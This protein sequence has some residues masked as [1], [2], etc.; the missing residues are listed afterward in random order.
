MIFVVDP[1]I[2][3]FVV[4]GGLFGLGALWGA[5]GRVRATQVLIHQAV[6]HTIQSLIADGFLAVDHDSAGDMVIL[7]LS[8]LVQRH[9]DSDAKV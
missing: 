1:H 4:A 7:P 9:V 8:Q 3:T 6:D 2:A 5:R